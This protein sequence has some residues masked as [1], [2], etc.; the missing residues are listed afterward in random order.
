MVLILTPSS[1]AWPSTGGEPMLD[2]IRV[3]LLSEEGFFV[4][5]IEVLDP[6][7]QTNMSGIAYNLDN[8]DNGKCEYCHMK[9][10]TPEPRQRSPSMKGSTL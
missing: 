2:S 5:N 8:S 9:I 3:P 10:I 1:F 6:G 4:Y 7:W